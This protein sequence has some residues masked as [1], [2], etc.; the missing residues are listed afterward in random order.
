M[1]YIQTT[2]QSNAA[3]NIRQLMY[4]MRYISLSV[5]KERY[6]FAPRAT[7]PSGMQRLQLAGLVRDAAYATEARA[8]GSASPAGAYHAAPPPVSRGGCCRAG[9][10][11][12]AKLYFFGTRR[13][14]AAD[15]LAKPVSATYE[16]RDRL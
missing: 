2:R 9:L 15:R 11:L 3:G 4:R 13:R 7:V 12:Q 1:I 10:A 8:P 5:R 6:N 16:G 14:T